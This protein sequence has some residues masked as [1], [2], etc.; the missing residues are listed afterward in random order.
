[1]TDIFLTSSSRIHLQTHNQHHQ[2][3]K[4]KTHIYYFSYFD[5][6]SPY[7]YLYNYTLFPI[8]RLSRTSITYK[9]MQQF[10]RMQELYKNVFVSV[11]LQNEERKKEVWLLLTFLQ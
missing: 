8:F 11:V 4:Q 1:M 10:E 9:Y 7:S 6:Y 5:S 2:S 3:T